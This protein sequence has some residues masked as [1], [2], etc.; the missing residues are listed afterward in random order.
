MQMKPPSCHL[1]SSKPTNRRW[2]EGSGL[3]FNGRGTE[4]RQHW[5]G[6]SVTLHNARRTRNTQIFHHF[7]FTLFEHLNREY[8]SLFKNIS[9]FRRIWAST[10]V[11]CIVFLNVISSLNRWHAAVGRHWSFFLC[12]LPSSF[13]WQTSFYTDKTHPPRNRTIL[14]YFPPFYSSRFDAYPWL[15]Y[16]E[17]TH[18]Q[19]TRYPKTK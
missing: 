18:K 17:S 7:F 19:T 9:G 4:T 10:V 16:C 1:T 13:R 11:F 2:K 3:V 15:K 8:G 6:V 5:H 12:F 14:V